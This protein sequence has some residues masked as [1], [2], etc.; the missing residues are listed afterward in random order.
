MIVGQPFQA[1]V[2][3][4]SLTYKGTWHARK[5]DLRHTEFCRS[6]KCAEKGCQVGDLS[7]SEHKV[8]R[9][10]HLLKHIVERPGTAIVQ[11][12]VSLADASQRRRIELAVSDFVNQSNVVVVW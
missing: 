6:L 11:Q 5:P 2:R 1:D 9:M 7:G 3:L 12:S 10:P 4:E 8:A